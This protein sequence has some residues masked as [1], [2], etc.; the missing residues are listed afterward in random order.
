MSTQD[1]EEQRTSPF[2][3]ALT[4][5]QIAEAVNRSPDNGVTIFLSKLGISDIGPYEAEELC[6]AGQQ[7]FQ[8]EGSSV[9][10]YT[11][12]QCSFRQA[13]LTLFL[14]PDWL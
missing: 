2:L 13:W 3:K 4:S 14:I 6:N 8:E 12:P 5:D 1:D 9:E 11:I 7:G 10:R